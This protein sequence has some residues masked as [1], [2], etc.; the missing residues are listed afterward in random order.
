MREFEELLKPDWEQFE[1]RRKHQ[2]GVHQLEQ[3]QQ[4]YSVEGADPVI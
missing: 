1:R 4:V 2:H 3:H